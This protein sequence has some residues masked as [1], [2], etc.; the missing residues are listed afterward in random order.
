MALAE[1]LRQLL[2]A[3]IPKRILHIGA[4]YGQEVVPYDKAGVASAVFVEAREDV[5][6]RLSANVRPRGYEALLALAWS[7]DGVVKDFLVSSNA[8]ASSSVFL[9]GDG[10]QKF[11]EIKVTRRLRLVT[12]RLDTE[13]RKQ[14]RDVD[15]FD[16]LVADVQGAEK[17]AIEGLG[18]YLG[19]IQQAVV[20]VSL[21]SLYD[22]APQVDEMIAFMRERGF[23]LRDLEQLNGYGDAL[24]CRVC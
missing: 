6:E 19:S 5:F 17:A 23:V 12:S 14:K 9:F 11:P 16:T 20:E 13:F 22:Q 7:E 10:M 18:E 1:P 2:Q 24:F 21:C 8:G 4:D 15:F 3:K